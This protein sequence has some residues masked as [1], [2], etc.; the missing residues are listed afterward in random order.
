MFTAAVEGKSGVS[1]FVDIKR[2][3]AKNRVPLER[4]AQT[5]ADSGKDVPVE[6]RLDV[7]GTVTRPFL[8]GAH[9]LARSFPGALMSLR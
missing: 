2:M 8:R 1:C 7:F 9:A 4:V 5:I 3:A 6:A